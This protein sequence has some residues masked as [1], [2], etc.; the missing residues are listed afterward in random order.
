MKSNLLVCCLFLISFTSYGQSD[1]IVER[2][3][4]SITNVKIKTF[5]LQKYQMIDDT[6]RPYIEN[7]IEESSPENYILNN[8]G[9]IS[10]S[11]LSIDRMKLYSKLEIEILGRKIAYIKYI[12]EREEKFLLDDII[13]LENIDNNWQ[14]IDCEPENE[15]FFVFKNMNYKSLMNFSGIVN[16][17]K[18]EVI[19]KYRERVVNVSGQLNISALKRE[20]QEN[21]AEFESLKKEP[22]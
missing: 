14:E 1:R 2:K 18:D 20:M 4:T 10:P 15:F 19:K 7:M 22:F 12:L 17:S 6:K 13:C 16:M 21:S 9:K 5:F 11:V 8:L 3:I